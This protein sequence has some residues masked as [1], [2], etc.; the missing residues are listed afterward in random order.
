MRFEL[1]TRLGPPSDWDEE[2]AVDSDRNLNRIREQVIEES[3]QLLDSSGQI[4]NSSRLCR[5][6]LNREKR[7]ITAIGDGIMI[8]HLRTLQTR[9]FVMAFA[10]ST[11]GLPLRAADNKPVHLFFPMVSPP[12]DDRLYLRVYRGLASALLDE[13]QRQTLMHTT[14]P[15]DVWRAL[16][17]FR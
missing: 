16:D 3:S 7:T 2:I 4:V 10:R 15:N 13:D 6:L 5:E 1:E 11:S 9:S 12:Y 14:E 17:L 8:P